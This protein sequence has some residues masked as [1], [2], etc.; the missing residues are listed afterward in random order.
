MS[1]EFADDIAVAAYR[2]DTQ[3]QVV[4]LPPRVTAD[5]NTL[6]GA[7]RQ[8]SG[9]GNVFGLLIVDEDFFV[10]A[11][12][13]GETVRLLISDVTAAT[14]WPIARDVLERLQL[15]LP[16]DDDPV[17]PGGDISIFEDCGFGPM[18]LAALCD[19]LDK[20]PDEML[21]DIARTIGFGPQLD[22]ILDSA[23]A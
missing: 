18:D 20:Y 14:D 7:V 9:S 3:W 10:V 8:I 21:S 5:I 16:D 1:E 12:V 19:D 17:Q 6:V 13:S 22:A 23:F 15:P 4:Q 2:D 11:R